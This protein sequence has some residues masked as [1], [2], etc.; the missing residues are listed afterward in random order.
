MRCNKSLRLLRRTLLDTPHQLQSQCATHPGT[1]AVAAL[2]LSAGVAAVRALYKLRCEPARLLPPQRCASLPDEAAAV[3]HLRR[4]D[5]R[6]HHLDEVPLLSRLRNPGPAQRCT[7]PCR[8]PPARRIGQSH[9][10]Q[11][12][13]LC[14]CP[15]CP[16]YSVAKTRPSCSSLLA[17]KTDLTSF[18]LR[19]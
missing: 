2:Q 9:H 14:S 7:A 17:S 18:H 4:S 3:E 10:G 1:F 19:S 12:S 13:N 11:S 6:Y 15:D 8:H 5:H 16:R